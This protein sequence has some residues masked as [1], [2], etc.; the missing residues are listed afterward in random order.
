MAQHPAVP[1]RRGHR[2]HIEVYAGRHDPSLDQ[3]PEQIV[4]SA[5][6][7]EPQLRH[8]F[9]LTNFRYSSSVSISTVTPSSPV[10]ISNVSFRWARTTTFAPSSGGVRKSSANRASEKIT[11]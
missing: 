10:S 11:G 1:F 5:G 4:R 7:R 9:S 3:W 6:Q 2:H 8:Y